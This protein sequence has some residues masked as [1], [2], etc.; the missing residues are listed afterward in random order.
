MKKNLNNLE[1][2]QLSREQMKEISG[3]LNNYECWCSNGSGFGFTSGVHDASATAASLAS[4]AGC[5]SYRCG[6]VR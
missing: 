1:F 2:N 5:S 4:Q 6:I 3:G